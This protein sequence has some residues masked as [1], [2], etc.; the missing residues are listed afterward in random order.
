MKSL[1]LVLAMAGSLAACIDA[2]RGEPVA[3]P[4]EPTSAA[5]KQ[6]EV[7]FD[8][9][10][11]KCHP[12]GEAGLGPA[13]NNKPLPKFLIHTQIRVG[14][15]TMPAIKKDELSEEQVELI[16]DYLE[17]LRRHKAGEPS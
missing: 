16:L 15:G 14:M 10:C 6:G 7:L 1:F 9:N 11:S 13:I 8:R 17:A 3:G 5:L 4:F 2:R 12:G